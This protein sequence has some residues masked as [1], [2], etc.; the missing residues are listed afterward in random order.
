[1]MYVP[2]SVKKQG[3]SAVKKY[4][5]AEGAFNKALDGAKA[6]SP[7]TQ[8]K[9]A[10]EFSGLPSVFRILRHNV[11]QNARVKCAFLKAQNRVV[12]VEAGPDESWPWLTSSEMLALLMK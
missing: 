1:M 3:K 6:R 2:D 10:R 4:I 11:A 7:E 8:R 5:A 9:Y 12:F